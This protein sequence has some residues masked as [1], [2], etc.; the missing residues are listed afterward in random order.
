MPWISEATAV[1]R[2]GKELAVSLKCEVRSLLVNSGQLYLIIIH[3]SMFC[4]RHCHEATTLCTEP[5][6]VSTTVKP[7]PQAI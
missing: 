3:A 1:R 6:T 4:K 5:F 7:T 2:L